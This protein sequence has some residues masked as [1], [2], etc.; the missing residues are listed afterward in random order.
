MGSPSLAGMIEREPAAFAADAM[1]ILDGP[2]DSAARPWCSA[3]A[4]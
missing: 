2:R 1:V 3:I 4:A